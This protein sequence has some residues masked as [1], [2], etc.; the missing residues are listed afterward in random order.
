MGEP[1]EASPRRV[2]EK[3]P[4]AALGATPCTAKDL[5]VPSLV[6]SSGEVLGPRRLGVGLP[7]GGAREG[8]RK[9]FSSQMTG[10]QAGCHFG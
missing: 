5:E 10:R 2:P 8:P 7:G 1:S 9:G 4:Q 6:D 3:V